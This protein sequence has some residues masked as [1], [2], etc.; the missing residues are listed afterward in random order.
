MIFSVV[1]VYA[2]VRLHLT[3]ISLSINLL[4][5]FSNN[6]LVVLSLKCQKITQKKN[7]FMFSSIM[8]HPTNSPKPKDN[9]FTM[10]KKTETLY[11]NKSGQVIT[12]IISLEDKKM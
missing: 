4:I 8:F 3:N 5:I 7:L 2:T 11:R 6:Q 1:I 9:L 12:G 10:I